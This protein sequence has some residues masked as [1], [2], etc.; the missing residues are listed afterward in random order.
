MSAT[1]SEVNGL[2]QE[3]FVALLGP[4]FEQSP[5]IAA[6]TWYARPFTSI[7]HLH[8][9]LCAVMYGAPVERQVALIRAHPD[10]VGREG[11]EGRAGRAARAGA[12]TPESR[13]EQASAGL[14]QLST[15]EIAT[16]TA[17]NAAYND[18]FG[19]PFVICVRENKKAGIL[20]GFQERLNHTRDEEISAALGEIAKISH[21]RL[22]DR[23]HQDSGE[24]DIVASASGRK[25]DTAG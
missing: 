13:S 12:L 8:D 22:L 5:W 4:V 15:E 18:R 9:A 19:F 20:A 2:D 10:L 16:F 24:D 25:T 7:A 11:R 3:R 23:V 21:P 1:L 6:A 17:L 14:D